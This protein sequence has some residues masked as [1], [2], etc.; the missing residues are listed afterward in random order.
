MKETEE[1]QSFVLK[2]DH[3]KL[4]IF[5]YEADKNGIKTALPWNFNAELTLYPAV[6]DPNGEVKI[7]DG[8]PLYEAEHPV[9][10]WMAGR[11]GNHG[12]DM[13]RAY[14]EMFTEYRDRFLRFSW[15]DPY[16]GGSAK[17]VEMF[18]YGNGEI[19]YQVWEMEDGREFSVTVSEKKGSSLKNRATLKESV[20]D[21]YVFK[22]QIHKNRPA[23]GSGTAESYD[24]ADGIHRIDKI[25]A[26]KYVL[27]ETK[28][29]DGY[30]AAAPQIINV[31]PIRELQRYSM[32]NI[33]KQRYIDKR[34]KAGNQLAGAELSLYRAGEDGELDLK[35]ELLEDR[36][37]SGK[38][39]RYDADD[40]ADGKI[41]QGYG[42]GD[43]RLH[44][45]PPLKYGSYYLVETRAPEY[46]IT[47]QPLK[48]ILNEE[49]A[50]VIT[51][52]NQMTE[53]KIEIKKTDSEWYEKPVP[54]AWFEIRNKR[55]EDTFLIRT[56]ETGAASSPMLPTTYIDHTYNPVPYEYE[57]REVRSPEGY[58]Q[59]DKI[60]R[61]VFT[62]EE[63]DVLVYRIEAE[64][65]R[66][67][68]YISKSDFETGDFV[69][70]AKLAI[71]KAIYKDGVY[72]PDGIALESW[73]SKKEPHPCIGK[74]S[75]GETYFLM[76][77]EAPEGYLVSPAVLFTISKDG[78]HVIE[79]AKGSGKII[80][81]TEESTGKLKTLSVL[82]RSVTG[83]RF[84]LKNR[85]QVISAG[86][87]QGVIEIPDQ[88]PE[89]ESL[90]VS[91][92]VTFSDG[93]EKAIKNESF[94]V[95]RKAGG[96]RINV[97]VPV[98]TEYLLSD[99]NGRSI[100]LW[101]GQGNERKRIEGNLW[102]EGIYRLEERLVFDDGSRIPVE[103]TD[104]GIGNRKAVDHLDMKDRKTEVRIRKTDRE[105][106]KWVP[107]AKLSIKDR[108]G[109]TIAS[110]NSGEDEYLLSGILKPG[111]EYRLV[112][113]Q[114]PEGYWKEED[115]LFT[116]SEDGR[117]DLIRMEDRKKETE[118]PKEPESPT[119]PNVPDRPK[120]PKEPEKPECPGDSK[121]PHP[122]AETPDGP[123]PGNQ[124]E[125]PT[126]PMKPEK[127]P[128]VITAKYAPST[129]GAGYADLRNPGK[130]RGKTG[131]YVP[132][133]G[134]SQNPLLYVGGMVAFIIA[135]AVILTLSRKKTADK[136][137]RRFN[138]F[139][140]TA[141][142]V[143]AGFQNINAWA[144][145]MSDPRENGRNVKIYESPVFVGE[146]KDLM[147]ADV[148]EED[149]KQ[150]RLVSMEEK[151]AVREKEITYAS[152]DIP[153]LLEGSQKP[154][155]TV[156]ITLK[157][158]YAQ[159]EYEREV[160][161]LKVTEK[162]VFWSDDFHFPLTV[163]GYDADS[164][165]IG[166]TEIPAEADMIRY[167]DALLEYLGL[168]ADCYQI[169]KIEW[170]GESYEKDGEK[171]RDGEAKGK[172]LVRSVSVKY[173]GQVEAPRLEG[174]Q[175]VAL[176]EEITRADM[177]TEETETTVSEETE[178]SAGSQID[179][180]ALQKF[181]LAERV[182]SWIRESRTVISVSIFFLLFLLS[183]L[184]L[185]FR[186]G[187]KGKYK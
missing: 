28:T 19:V 94:R 160:P 67:R 53:G 92:W 98:K 187:K 129:G 103:R 145:E 26:G 152:A 93:S 112:E 41:P 65:D 96:C 107:G 29:P 7:Q 162:D 104:L 132:K 151:D 74:L 10:S 14:E 49:T 43:M 72:I 123:G 176:Y 99:K 127:R 88:I 2:D 138:I 185:F 56:D 80:M 38:E 90:T 184:L 20:K 120:P 134:D 114:A 6:L 126:E 143:M 44:K 78:S 50:D 167:E 63:N 148:I 85:E 58:Q 42:I 179:A 113:D 89:G 70:G 115:I 173:G 156:L 182:L 3:I 130:I 54:G 150:Y 12:M 15:K 159:S 163:T 47:M 131:I 60:W 141:F 105:S 8:R 84:V 31:L 121:N 106:G 116:V 36:W 161:L 174:R 59:S 33:K 45:I 154:P 95:Y 110:W 32:E 17:R 11:L 5:K 77:E 180:E 155:D 81:D 171:C 1:L 46:F 170:S 62:P 82:C 66:T 169:N 34:D 142:L 73:S 68:L 137:K 133:T 35:E 177:D 183:A 139:L 39:G 23:L 91:Q 51:A 75:A 86:E 122:P 146:R 117:I 76:E 25:P 83:G 144:E 181:S 147:P 55:T 21:R 22:Y 135:A 9:D 87:M 100:V 119:K 69:P 4:E 108:N 186:T 166:E 37:I 61:V 168:S 157:D 71:Y 175:Y 165:R 140:F 158:E 136:T 101:D 118:P 57:V 109:K 48:I 111:E 24:T 125:L 16:G 164:F 27:V 30:K 128:G 52:V 124:P 178:A 172:K 18:S 40:L 97:K 79:I 13:T 102:T 153:Y 64:N 149:G